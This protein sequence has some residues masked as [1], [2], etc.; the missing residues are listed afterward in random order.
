MTDQQAFTCLRRTEAGD[1]WKATAR[2]QV[3]GLPEFKEPPSGPSART[4]DRFV[5][6][7]VRHSFDG[8]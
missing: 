7:C 4:E 5:A 1:W 8:H 3:G 6:S 2:C